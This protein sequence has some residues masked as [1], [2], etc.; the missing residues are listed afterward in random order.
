MSKTVVVLGGDGVGPE[1]ADAAA[2]VL[3][4]MSD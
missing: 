2:E 1:V 3:E 4:K